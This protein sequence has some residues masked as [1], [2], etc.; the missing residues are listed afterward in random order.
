MKTEYPDVEAAE[1]LTAPDVA[2]RAER[3]VD[4]HKDLRKRLAKKLD[5]GGLPPGT[6]AAKVPEGMRRGGGN[7]TPKAFPGRPSAQTIELGDS[8]AARARKRKKD[9]AKDP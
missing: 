7:L 3:R 9:Q 5:L 8:I 2:V 1:T 6:P 4:F